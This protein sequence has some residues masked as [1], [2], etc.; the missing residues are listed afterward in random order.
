[1]PSDSTGSS[2]SSAARG[3]RAGTIIC[4]MLLS[5]RLYQAPRQAIVVPEIA[6]IQVGT[7]AFVYRVSNEQTA[8]RVKVGLGS[9]RRGEVEITSGLAVG[10]T[11]VS[12]GS[13]KLRDGARIASAPPPAA[14]AAAK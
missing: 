5:V 12:E 2:E 4:S 1:M 9:R 14:E 8:E 3:F 11:I 10:D 6:V 13:V 7:E